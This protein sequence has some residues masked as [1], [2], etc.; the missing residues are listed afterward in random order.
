MQTDAHPRT[1]DI[2]GVHLDS[3]LLQ[4]PMVGITD[5]L[6]RRIAHR[7]GCGVALTEMLYARSLVEGRKEMRRWFEKPAGKP[8]AVQ[9]IGAHPQLVGEAVRIAFDRG[10][11]LVDL[12]FGCSRRK[13]LRR[14]AGAAL[15]R[16]QHQAGE[17]FSAAVASAA[18]PVTV[19]I[20]LGPATGQNV[21]RVFARLA[22]E[23][24]LAAVTVHGRFST[25]HYGVPIDRGAIEEVVDAVRIPVI[26]NGDVLEPKDGLTLFHLTGCAGI[27]VGRGAIGNP[28]L[29][30]RIDRLV[31]G[32]ADPG[33]PDLDERIAVMR[34]HLGDLVDWLGEA[35]AVRNFRTHLSGYLKGVVGN[36]SLK[37]RLFR[38]V[39]L[40]QFDAE[41][42]EFRAFH[43]P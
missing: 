5:H 42:S 19:K 37:L 20:R 11:D 36:D 32:G 9:I 1:L 21:A 2:G 29:F 27:M 16:D 12:N 25:G 3:P 40:E 6:Q 39:T 34:G 30:A 18:G 38:C 43:G 28:W 23:S 41:M 31:A 14:G 4:A 22:Q 26:G 13:V 17:I 24:G 33:A 7:F 35:R 15:L 8:L 10:A